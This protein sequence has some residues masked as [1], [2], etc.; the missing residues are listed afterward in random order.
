MEIGRSLR[1]ARAAVF[2]AVC[3]SVSAAGHVWMSGPSIPAWALCVAVLSV[4]GAGYALSGRQRGF[5]S[6]APLMLTGQ[7]G[8]HL[9]FAAGQ[10]TVGGTMAAMP[11]MPDMSRIIMPRPVPASA[12]LCGGAM[13]ASGASPGHGMA[14][15][16]AWMTAYGS[17]GM[18][19]VHAA[20]GLLAA[21]WL[22][23]G[24]AAV[25]RLLNSF[26]RF[27]LPLL[28]LAWPGAL[29]V[30]DLT[31]GVAVDA[32]ERAPSG[33]VLLVHALVRRGPPAPV[34]CM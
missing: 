19:A 10:H 16:M 5:A 3:V 4:G 9:L 12:W 28:M 8:L 32:H 27:A 17:A 33:R 30:P 29:T 21:W 7:L 22:C 23:R 20:A 6:I 18:I 14:A 2:A 34:F 13:T 24:E 31:A 25:F 11:G 15:T 1:T 26:A